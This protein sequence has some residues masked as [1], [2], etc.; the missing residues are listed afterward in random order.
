M[1]LSHFVDCWDKKG[2][3]CWLFTCHT[4]TYSCTPAEMLFASLLQSQVHAQMNSPRRARKKQ[5]IGPNRFLP[6][7]HEFTSRIAVCESGRRSEI[8]PLNLYRLNRSREQKDQYP[9]CT[10]L[11]FFPIH[12]LDIIR[13][14]EVVMKVDLLSFTTTNESCSLVL[15]NNSSSYCIFLKK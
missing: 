3:R 2:S 15:N 6:H 4:I 10:F 1:S 7:R 5:W 8:Q 13:T 12:H 11:Y 14:V 9:T